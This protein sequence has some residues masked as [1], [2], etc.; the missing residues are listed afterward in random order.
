MHTEAASAAAHSGQNDLFLAH[1]K[2]DQKFENSPKMAVD[3]VMSQK[4]LTA[5]VLYFD[6]P[7]A[8]IYTK[9]RTP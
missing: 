2:I 9:L 5:A 6:F 1:K 7:W 4:F 8:Y 3:F